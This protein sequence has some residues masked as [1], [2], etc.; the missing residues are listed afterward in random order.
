MSA[1]APTDLV[2][3]FSQ[4]GIAAALHPGITGRN[5]V[6]LFVAYR[7]DEDGSRLPLTGK[8]LESA[9][10]RSTRGNR[11]CWSLPA[12]ERL[13]EQIEQAVDSDAALAECE[14]EMDAALIRAGVV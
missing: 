5:L 14:A 13:L 8:N 3:R 10:D 4:C 1:M 2:S 9:G 6:W 11:W 7:E 12:A